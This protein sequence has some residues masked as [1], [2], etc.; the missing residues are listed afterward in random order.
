MTQPETHGKLLAK[1]ADAKNILLWQTAF[2][3]DLILT[4]PLIDEIHRQFP[5]ADLHIVTNRGTAGLLADDLRVSSVI[6]FDKRG[7]DRGLRGMLRI[8]HRVRSLNCDAAF[9]PHRSMRSAQMVF[10]C[11]IP[12]RIGFEGTPGAFL[13]TERVQRDQEKHEIRRNLD[14]LGT[15]SPTETPRPT[16]PESQR[17]NDEVSALLG[18]NSNRLL[19]IAPGSV[20]ATKKWPVEHW[21]ELT[22]RLL[23]ASSET[24]IVVVGGPEDHALGEEIAQKD[25]SRIF[26]AA[27]ELRIPSSIALLRRCSA[28]ITGDTAPLHMGS[29]AGIPIIAIFGPTVPEFGFAPTGPKDLI[30]GLDLDCRPCAIH[31][32]KVCPKG[33]HNCMKNL[34]PQYVFDCIESILHNRKNVGLE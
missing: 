32:S 1:L 31:G 5:D 12:V 26:N 7:N 30:L 4:L 10:L 3:G 28:L 19:A 34:T 21:I 9:V 25:S 27:G 16:L 14:L 23:N 6:P 15:L 2:L 11:G 17:A 24:T 18:K 33:H 20:W 13:Y 22:E 8:I 29:T